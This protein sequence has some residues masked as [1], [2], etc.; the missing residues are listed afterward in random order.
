MLF[1][2][3]KF[4]PFTCSICARP[5]HGHH[6]NV[7]TCKGCKTF[8]RRQCLLN[9]SEKCDLHGDC[10]DLKKRNSPLLRCRPC[11]FQKCKSVGMKPEWVQY[12][13]PSNK[14][15]AT[16]QLS[17]LQNKS[18]NLIDPLNYVEWKLE[19]FRRSS[20]NPHWHTLG[21]L[22]YMLR[23][24]G[25][26]AS[27]EKYGPMPGWPIRITIPL[28]VSRNRNILGSRGTELARCQSRKVWTLFNMMTIIEY[29]KTFDF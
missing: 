4:K 6:Y 25:V 26:L 14:I 18:Q 7:L 9:T 1:E 8:F 13:E 2:S 24:D 3:K 20:Y 15:I 5:A 29:M 11:R 21:A 10:F 27:A 12:K 16:H 19:I 22:D 17:S 28:P 23:R